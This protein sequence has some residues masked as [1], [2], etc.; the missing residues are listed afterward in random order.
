MALN[1][2]RITDSGLLNINRKIIGSRKYDTNLISNIGNVS[3]FESIASGFDISSYLCASEL[4]FP[5]DDLTI[6][7][8]A[9]FAQSPTDQLVYL[10]KGDEHSIELHFCDEQSRL[11][12][13]DVVVLQ[14]SYLKLLFS[15]Y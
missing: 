14:F 12:V 10:L 3:I 9:T 5:K 2:M 4:S 11:I 6:T 7:C 15:F 13:D 8:T 1:E